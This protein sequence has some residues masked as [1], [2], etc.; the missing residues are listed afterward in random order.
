MEELKAKSQENKEICL[1]PVSFNFRVWNRIKGW[2]K[3]MIEWIKGNSFIIVVL[4]FMF[5]IFTTGNFNITTCSNII[6]YV[7][8]IV[9]GSV[10][11]IS[12][13]V[14]FI[15]LK[16]SDNK[17]E[18][19]ISLTKEKLELEVNKLKNEAKL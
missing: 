1:K 2:I 19:I 16:K 9:F 8:K 15:M 12:I 7:Y 4:S 11:S 13:M 5:Y 3:K 10:L 17:Q 18:E 6:C 14:L